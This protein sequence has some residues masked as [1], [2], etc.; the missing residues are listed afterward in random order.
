MTD[1]IKKRIEQ[2]KNGKG[3]EKYTPTLLGIR[4][5]DWQL[6][7]IGA[8]IKS[9]PRPIKMNDNDKYQLI[10][11]RRAYGGV[12]SRGIYQ[13]EKILVKSQF[14]IALGDF[15]IS[16]RQIVH[17]AC[18]IARLESDN[19]IVSN[20][21]NVFTMNAGYNLEYFNFSM[22]LPKAKHLFYVMSIGV[23]IEKMLF[24][25]AEWLRQKIA[26]PP[27]AE[28]DKIAEILTHCDKLIKLKKQLIAEECKQKKW[29]MQNLLNPD[30][31]VRLEGFEGE[32]EKT[33]VSNIS[34]YKSSSISIEDVKSL[35]SGIHP[36]YDA[37]SIIAHVDVY[38][39]DEKYIS[40]IK[41]GAGIGRILRC[42]A[43]SSVIGTMGYIFPAQTVSY[44]YFYYLLSIQNFCQYATGS[45]IPHVYYSEYKN[46]VVYLPPIDEQIAIANI[47]ST[48]DSKIG[49]LEQE[50]EQWQQKK[51]SLMQLLLTGIVRVNV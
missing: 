3:P 40:I 6:K 16:K 10:T 38:R 8:A 48:A 15:I 23:H 13:G 50:L 26:Y 20:E 27:N 45:T 21:Y 1:E 29:L 44:D 4:P 33:T 37:S 47:L 19:A 28:Q 5:S 49:L 12:V 43:K 31:G 24:G 11:V 42:V 7:K 36:V 35:N 34:R 18:G 9:T 32:W 46:I 17:G 2:V 51:K 30:S 39:S 22:Q 41:D 14:R 25:T